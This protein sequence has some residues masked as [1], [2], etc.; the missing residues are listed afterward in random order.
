[1]PEVKKLLQPRTYRIVWNLV[2]PAAN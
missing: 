2:S 1:M